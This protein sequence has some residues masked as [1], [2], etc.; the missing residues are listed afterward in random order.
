[1]QLYKRIKPFS[2]KGVKNNK[3]RKKR[4][5][6]TK[7]AKI[8]LKRQKTAKNHKKCNFPQGVVLFQNNLL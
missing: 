3:D 6:Q 7:T 2:Q 8:R 1:M 4:Q 5:K